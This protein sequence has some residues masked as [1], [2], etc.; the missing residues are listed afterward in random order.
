MSLWV[1]A[2]VLAIVALFVLGPTIARQLFVEARDDPLLGALGLTRRQRFL[3]G[4]VRVLPMALAGAALAV[5]VAIAASPLMPIGVAESAEPN[6]GVE[7]NVAVLSLGA[8]AVAGLGTL[9]LCALIPLLNLF[10]S[11]RPRQMMVEILAKGRDFPM[12][13]VHHVFAVN[14]I[15]FEPRE[16]SQGEEAEA[17]Y[18]TTLKPT[19]A[20]EDLSAQLIG[21]GK[22][23]IKNVSWSP[24]KRG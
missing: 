21:D 8:L 13:H 24:P 18:L 2:F 22:K 5:L 3:L 19:D 20:L 1:F 11:E 12:A 16:V 4:E 17:K 14:G 6:P 7:V 9:F 10:S 15:L 23:G